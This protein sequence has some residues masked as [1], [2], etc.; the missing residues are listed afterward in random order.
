MAWKAALLG[1]KTVTSFAESSVFT[2]FALLRAPAAALRPA[3][4]AVLEMF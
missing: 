3:A 4:T 2:R 1:A